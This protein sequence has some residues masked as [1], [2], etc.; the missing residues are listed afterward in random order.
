MTDYELITFTVRV[1]TSA[2]A[3]QRLEASLPFAVEGV[4]VLGCWVSDI[5]PQ[6]RIALLRG[7]DNEMTKAVERDRCLLTFDAFGIGEYLLDQTIDDYRLFPFLTLL[8]PGAHGPFYELREYNLVPS[9]LAPTLEG[10]K[11]AIE[12]R[13]SSQYSSVY[14]AFYA[15]SGRTPRYLHLWPYASLEQR[16]EVRG[17][18]VKDGAWLPRNSAPQL[19]QMNSAIYLPAHFSPLR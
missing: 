10:W 9:G 2:P 1:G 11:Q 12:R 18:A 7:F 13:A 5:G 17:R 14:A 8:A 6:N 16:S 4:I 3:L 15:T 19:M